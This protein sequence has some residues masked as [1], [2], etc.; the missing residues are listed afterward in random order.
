M[1]PTNKNTLSGG[2]WKGKK[3]KPPAAIKGAIVT[4]AI[5]GLTTAR[6]ASWLLNVLNLR[7]A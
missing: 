2:G 3:E 7:G 5:C 1:R 4:L 6:W